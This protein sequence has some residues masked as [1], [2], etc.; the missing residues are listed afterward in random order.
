[1][2]GINT[3][4]KREFRSIEKCNLDGYHIFLATNE[5]CFYKLTKKQGDVIHFYAQFADWLWNI[6][7]VQY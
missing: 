4:G 7:I 5:H 3:E 1:M 6:E 2:G